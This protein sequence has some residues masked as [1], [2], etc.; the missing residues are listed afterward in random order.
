MQPSTQTKTKKLLMKDIEAGNILAK[1]TQR[2]AG[3]A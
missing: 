3:L 1:S 2:E